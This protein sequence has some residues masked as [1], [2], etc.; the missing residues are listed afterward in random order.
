MSKFE[1]IVNDNTAELENIKS[2]RFRSSSLVKFDVVVGNAINLRY[3]LYTDDVSQAISLPHAT[4][5]FDS[6]LEKNVI[7]L[8]RSTG[9]FN[10]CHT[11]NSQSMCI[12]S[13]SQFDPIVCRFKVFE[14][15]TRIDVPVSNVNVS[16]DASYSALHT[17]AS[18][19]SLIAERRLM[20]MLQEQLKK[21]NDALFLNLLNAQSPKSM[22][23]VQT[24]DDEAVEQMIATFDDTYLC[25]FLC[26]PINYRLLSRISF[27]LHLP[28]CASTNVDQNEVFL[29][30]PPNC[31]GVSIVSSDADVHVKPHDAGMVYHASLVQSIGLLVTNNFAKCRIEN[32]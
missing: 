1:F 5:L 12:E 25:T 30:S 16:V 2:A 17:M 31:F 3:S 28:I 13:I 18:D 27:T 32:G 4:V 9:P 21:F 22:T 11:F 15:N 8:Q 20:R 29:I 10:C 19:N 7:A 14:P 6:L 26:H 23:F 24:F